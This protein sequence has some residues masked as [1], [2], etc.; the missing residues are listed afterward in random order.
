MESKDSKQITKEEKA[1][2]KAQR[3]AEFVSKFKDFFNQTYKR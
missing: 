1:L 2:A 3:K